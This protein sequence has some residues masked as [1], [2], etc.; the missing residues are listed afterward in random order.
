MLAGYYNEKSE[1]HNMFGDLEKIM[2]TIP[3]LSYPKQ[4][5]HHGIKRHAVG[6]LPDNRCTKCQLYPIRDSKLCSDAQKV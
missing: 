3:S 5:K 1:N 6:R 4:H 2:F